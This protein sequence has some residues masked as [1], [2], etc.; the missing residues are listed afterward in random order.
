MEIPVA[1]Q[2]FYEP[3]PQ[4]SVAREQGFDCAHFITDHPGQCV[5][6]H[7]G[8]YRM[9][10][11]IEDRIDPYTG[12]VLDYGYLSQ[13][14]KKLVV[15]RLDHQCLNQVSAKLAWRS[16]TELINEFAWHQLL[17]YLPNMREIQTYETENHTA[18]SAAL[19]LKERERGSVCRVNIF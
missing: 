4:A 1:G 13:A 18:C 14:I 8:H 12:F 3:Q 16:S 19:R 2:R 11:K 9:I 6:L 7:G 17:D 5:N 10:V 15:N